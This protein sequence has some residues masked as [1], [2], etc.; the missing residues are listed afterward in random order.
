MRTKEKI[1]DAALFPDVSG[2]QGGAALPGAAD[3][4]P[5]GHLVRFAHGPGEVRGTEE[6]RPV[7]QAIRLAAKGRSQ[8][9]L[10]GR[11]G[12]DSAATPIPKL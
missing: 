3:R 2:Q 8:G 7:E 12:H 1:S 5:P 4:H 9:P 11:P 6:N 10:T